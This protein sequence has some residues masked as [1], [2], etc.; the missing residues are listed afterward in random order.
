MTRCPGCRVPH[1]VP[2]VAQLIAEDEVLTT[3]TV[4]EAEV[5]QRMVKLCRAWLVQAL[6]GLGYCQQC[7]VEKDG[8]IA[9]EVAMVSVPSS[10]KSN[11]Q[12]ER[13]FLDA[14]EKVVR[15]DRSKSRPW[16]G[17]VVRPGELVSN[18]EL[19]RRDTDCLPGPNDDCM[20]VEPGMPK[21]GA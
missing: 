6:R 16:V 19:F 2:S 11:E 8:A 21:R 17:G 7:I 10:P 1:E 3:K 15:I 12:I 13:Q 9:G 18:H 14:G 4:L 5:D 20:P